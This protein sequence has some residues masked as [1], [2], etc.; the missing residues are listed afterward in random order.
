[1]ASARAAQRR[2]EPEG[3]IHSTRDHNGKLKMRPLEE[4]SSPSPHYPQDS[5]FFL[6]QNQPLSSRWTPS[7]FGSRA[8]LSWPSKVLFYPRGWHCVKYMINLAEIFALEVHKAQKGNTEEAC[9]ELRKHF[10]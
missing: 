6:L 4:A 5:T 1:M 7:H 8:Y 10:L 9:Q 3:S 2:C